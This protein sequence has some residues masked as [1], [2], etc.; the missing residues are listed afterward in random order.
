MGSVKL[1]VTGGARSGKSRHAQRVAQSLGPER[2]FIAT[3]TRTDADMARRIE[4]HRADR[5]AG[6]TTVEEPLEVAPLLARGPVVLL[7]CL[8]LWLSNCMLRDPDP[9]RLERAFDE[10]VD[11]IARA[12]HHVILVTNEVGF[13]VHPATA[14]GRAFRDHAGFLAQRVAQVCDRVV[15]MCAGIPIELPPG[16]APVDPSISAD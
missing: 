16:N 5:G 9:A 8:T 15:L 10:L 13:G 14:L 3:A 11:A 7:D 1:L 12:P 6:W 2:I 4:R